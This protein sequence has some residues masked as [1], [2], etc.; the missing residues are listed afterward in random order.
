M[1]ERQGML[2]IFSKLTGDT[3]PSSQP[4]ES[5]SIQA[6]NSEVKYQTTEAET[7]QNEIHPT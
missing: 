3:L 5:E 4:V 2:G 7:V 6:H 1:Q